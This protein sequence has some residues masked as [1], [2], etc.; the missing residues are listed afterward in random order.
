MEIVEQFS[1]AAEQYVCEEHS[2]HTNFNNSWKLILQPRWYTF[3]LEHLASLQSED[4]MQSNAG[5][6][7]IQTSTVLTKTSRQHYV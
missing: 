5:C 3:N 4:Y 7:K 1:I 2:T 6:N